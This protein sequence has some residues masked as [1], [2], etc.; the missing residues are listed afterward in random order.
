MM[1]LEK[2]L[3]EAME[4]LKAKVRRAADDS[5][6]RHLHLRSLTLTTRLPLSCAC[7]EPVLHLSRC[8]L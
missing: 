8:R 3:K 2:E 7:S 6:H 4:L 5:G 1:G